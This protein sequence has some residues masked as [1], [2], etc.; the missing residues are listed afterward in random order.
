MNNSKEKVTVTMFSAIELDEV[1]KLLENNGYEVHAVPLSLDET[2]LIKD[3][4]E[5][6]LWIIQEKSIANT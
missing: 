6:R 4:V 3:K 5:G 1:R 2:Y